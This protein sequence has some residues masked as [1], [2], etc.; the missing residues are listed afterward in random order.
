MKTADSF[1]Y[2]FR[3]YP[4]FRVG[5]ILV[6]ILAVLLVI[7][8]ITYKS[9][10]IPVIASVTPPIG[11]PGDIMIIYGENFGSVRTTS[12][13]VEV[14]GSRITASGYILWQ[15]NQIK[16]V[17]PSNVQDGLVIVAT[18]AGKSKP[19]FFA[20][21][22]GIPV[23]ERQP[24]KVYIDS[25]GGCLDDTL[26][27]I[28]AISMSKTP[29]WTICVGNAYSG[30]FFTFI[31]G[32]KRIAYPMSS[33][34]FHEGSTNSGTVDAGKFRN[35]AD[36]YSRQME[37]LKKVTLKYTKISEEDYEHH[38]KDD[39]WFFAEEGIQYGFVDEIAKELI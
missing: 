23:E 11:S 25:N 7:S 33:F 36:F 32:H 30:G 26:T 16:I 39:W 8:F 21:E 22:A 13:Y 31:A 1:K 20:N 12:D 35:Y 38:R 28:D 4:F 29:V 3:K 37:L 10:K 27:M 17:L 19:G 9:R 5:T 15:D 6:S 18:K 14:G 2:F 34:M 24:I